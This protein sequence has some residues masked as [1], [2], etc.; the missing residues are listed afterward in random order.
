[1]I[2][3]FSNRKSPKKYS[4]SEYLQEPISFPALYPK[5]EI[6]LILPF[7]NSKQWHLWFHPGEWL[8]LSQGDPTEAPAP[9]LDQLSISQSRTYELMC[10]LILFFLTDF[11]QFSN[12]KGIILNGVEGKWGLWRIILHLPIYKENFKCLINI[13]AKYFLVLDILRFPSLGAFC[14]SL[15]LLL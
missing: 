13:R 3:C 5:K 14:C 15:Y 11:H 2:S 9:V 7:S 4:V 12:P 8:P 1:M 10:L 6:A